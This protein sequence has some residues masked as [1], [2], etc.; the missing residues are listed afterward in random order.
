MTKNTD[1]NTFRNTVLQY[2][3]K[4][5]EGG[6]FLLLRS[7]SRTLL[8][9]IE[10]PSSG[11]TSVYLA[12]DISIGAAIIYIRPLQKDLDLAPVVTECEVILF[13]KKC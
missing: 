4:L 2:Y 10:P 12:D 7:A 6:G 9:V 11:Y 5:R 8:D 1:P 3:L 13:K